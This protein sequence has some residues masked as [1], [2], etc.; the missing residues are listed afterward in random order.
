MPLS[1]SSL[2]TSTMP[3][4]YVLVGRAGELQALEDLATV[5]DIED[6]IACDGSAVHAWLKGVNDPQ[7]ELIQ[8][9]GAGE[10]PE[11]EQS[12]RIDLV[13]LEGVGKGEVGGRWTSADGAPCSYLRSGRRRGRCG[14]VPLGIAS[15]S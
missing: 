1:F 8:R 6:Q 10:V 5:V 3:N 4:R 15:P 2:S 9:V 12:D 11:Q 7:C 13:D 14:G